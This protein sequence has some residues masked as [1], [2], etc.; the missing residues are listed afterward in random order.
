MTEY[1]WALDALKRWGHF[2]YYVRSH[3][4][5]KYLCPV[6]YYRGDP[7]ARLAEREDKLLRTVEAR[8]ANWQVHAA[9]K[10]P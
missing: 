7:V 1:Y 5:L 3:S 4:A 6:D 10:E 9:V 8:R 2:Y